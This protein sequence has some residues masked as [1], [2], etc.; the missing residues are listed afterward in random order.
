VMGLAAV[1]V[2]S[3]VAIHLAAR[4]GATPGASS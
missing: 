2:A 1:F 4:A 3:M